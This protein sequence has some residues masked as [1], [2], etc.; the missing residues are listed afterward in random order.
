MFESLQGK[1]LSTEK[2]EAL[3]RANDISVQSLVSGAKETLETLREEGK[4]HAEE[5]SKLAQKS[6]ELYNKSRDILADCKNIDAAIKAV[7][8]SQGKT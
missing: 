6:A 4:F 1:F 2:L 8:A 3:L 5:S 7:D